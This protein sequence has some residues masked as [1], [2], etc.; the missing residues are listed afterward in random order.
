MHSYK[1]NQTVTYSFE[2]GIFP[3]QSYVYEIHPTCLDSC[4]SFI[5]ITIEQVFLTLAGLT[6]WAR[7]FFGM[8][9][10]SVHCGIF[11]S[12]PSL[13]SLNTNAIPPN[14]WLW[15]PKIS[16][17][18]AKCPLGVQTTPCWEPLLYSVSLYDYTI[19]Y[20]FYCWWALGCFQ[21]KVII[22]STVPNILIHVYDFKCT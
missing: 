15:Q 18:I 4:F 10:Y 6:S 21:F 9:D 17:D 19:I 12:I 13:Y 1:W 16:L 22:N 11:C 7:C 8:R 20:P 14:T 5:F 3:S 2:I